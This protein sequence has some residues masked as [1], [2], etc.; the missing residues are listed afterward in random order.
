[1]DISI[2]AKEEGKRA[3]VTDNLHLCY[4]GLSSFPSMKG[5]SLQNLTRLDLSYNNLSALPREVNYHSKYQQ[6]EYG[7][8]CVCRSES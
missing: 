5:I 2:I 1:M 4:M 3:E 8:Y 7:K 6:H